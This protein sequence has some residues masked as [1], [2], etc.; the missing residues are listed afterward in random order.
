MEVRGLPVV[1]FSWKR[2]LSGVTLNVNIP[3][4]AYF[5]FV[6]SGKSIVLVVVGIVVVGAVVLILQ[7]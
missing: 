2:V 1:V 5:C 6:S 3:I 7:E 4:V